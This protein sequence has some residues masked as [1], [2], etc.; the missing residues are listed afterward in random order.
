MKKTETSN[1]DHR[2]NT[3]TK[4]IVEREMNEPVRDLFRNCRT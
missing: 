4:H 3:S 2:I 1:W